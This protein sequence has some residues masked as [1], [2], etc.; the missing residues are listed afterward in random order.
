[1]NLGFVSLPAGPLIL[2]ASVLAALAAGRFAT[3]RTTGDDEGASARIDQ[4]IF[5]TLIVGLVVARL[6]FV[7]R[8]LPGYEGSIGKM[9]DFR[10]LGFDLLA[11]AAAGVCVLAWIML[12]RRALRRPLLIA[13]AAGVATWSAASAAAQFAQAPQSVPQVSLV[14]SAGQLQPLARNDGKPLVVNLWATW[15]PPCRAE[16]PVLARAQADHARIDV[17]FVNQGEAK[18][19]VDDYLDSQGI[20]IANSM[21]DPNLAVAR[22]VEAAGFPTTL[23]YDARGRLLARHLGPFSRATFEA[24]LERF[25]PAVPAQK[26]EAAR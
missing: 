12:R 2:F 16:M 20:R 26:Q 23:F 22:A 21:L 1:M 7:G 17:V 24:A 10:D 25:Y 18:A 15:C 14:D 19:T 5:N 6:V 13:V 4:S 8:Y 9:L 3:R 11:G